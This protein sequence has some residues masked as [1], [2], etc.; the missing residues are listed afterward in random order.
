MM[1]SEVQEVVGFGG[2]ER[3]LAIQEGE[4][5]GHRREETETYRDK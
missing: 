2:K 5:V 3:K 4:D 1:V